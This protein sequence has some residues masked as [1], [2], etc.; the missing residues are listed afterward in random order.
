MV[1]CWQNTFVLISRF[2]GHILQV[3]DLNAAKIFDP[4]ATHEHQ[5]VVPRRPISKTILLSV[6]LWRHALSPLPQLPP[7]G[8]N[9]LLDSEADR[10]LCS[11]P[12]FSSWFHDPDIK[13]YL[14]YQRYHI[15]PQWSSQSVVRTWR[16]HCVNG[17]QLKCMQTFSVG[18]YNLSVT[19]GKNWRFPTVSVTI[20]HCA[21]LTNVFLLS[22]ISDVGVL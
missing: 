13:P 12:N 5:H 11:Y 9:E 17:L 18:A 19:D 22:L 21:T 20:D 4:Q 15:T 16:G 3:G 6:M 2:D 8:A 7:F 1:H 10:I 14:S